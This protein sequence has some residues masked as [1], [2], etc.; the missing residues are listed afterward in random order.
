M[1]NTFSN[2]VGVGPLTLILYPCIHL[3][4][5]YGSNRGGTLS[6]GY[7]WLSAQIC[8]WVSLSVWLVYYYYC[9]VSVESVRLIDS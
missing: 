8:S 3:I 7:I 6:N 2:I 9:L 4:I 1:L 5:A